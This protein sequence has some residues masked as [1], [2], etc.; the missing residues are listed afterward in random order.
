MNSRSLLTIGLILISL[1]YVLGDIFTLLNYYEAYSMADGS[2]A[3]FG[4][5]PLIFYSFFILFI[6]KITILL[7]APAIASYLLPTSEAIIPGLQISDVFLVIGIAICIADIPTLIMSIAKYKAQLQY[8]DDS[9]KS[10]N[11]KLDIYE[12]AIRLVLAF[13]LIYWR[14]DLL[15]KLDVNESK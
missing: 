8:I 12:S 9:Y 7:K 15:D 3:D 14:K 10:F 2:S 6:L 5:S 13:A 4:I 11:A 1:Y